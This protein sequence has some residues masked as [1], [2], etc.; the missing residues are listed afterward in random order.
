MKIL[1]YLYILIVLIIS[2]SIFSPNISSLFNSPPSAMVN[3]IPGEMNGYFN[4]EI[5]VNMNR[6]SNISVNVTIP[7][8]NESYQNV[9]LSI[10]QGPMH[11][12]HSAYNRTWLSFHVT[13]PVKILLNYSFT[14]R[15]INYEVSQW[16]SLNQ[17]AI[18][19]FL[20]Q[21][22]DHPEYLNNREVISPELFQN[23][24]LEIVEQ[25]NA[26]NVFQ[27][28]KALYDFIV[29]NFKYNLTYS[30]LKTPQTA[31]ET[32]ELKEGDCAELSFL[33]A[34]M[35]RAI[36][37]PAWL[38]FGWYFTG[39]TWAEHAWIGT[40]IPTTQGLV[41]GIIDLTKEVGG[42]DLGMGFFMK[43]TSRITEWID[44]GN[45]THLTNYYT[46]IYGTSYG[47]VTVT[48]NVISNNE[49]F[50]NYTIVSD[51]TYAIEPILFE[52]AFIG[53]SAVIVYE[54]IRRP[55]S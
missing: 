2:V 8:A 5:V 18:P 42:N 24:S 44:D 11:D 20:Q 21:Q 32:W 48:D 13:E 52:I 55:K 23:I 6:L 22:Y 4:R 19:F 40:V 46:F 26:K 3:I 31:W 54:I 35:S 38:E 9:S 37:I 29:K 51:P 16:N 14:I 36:G 28:E 25:A 53:V 34:S 43:G 45:S 27:E 15:P 17:S 1:A 41:Y 49:S 10:I 12:I 7:Y 30:A 33:Y 47:S 39:V 50:G